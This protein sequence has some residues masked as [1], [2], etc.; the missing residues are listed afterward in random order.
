MV[1][2]TL[3]YQR[4]LDAGHFKVTKILNNGRWYPVAMITPKGKTYLAKRHKEYTQARLVEVAI[5]TQV[6]AMV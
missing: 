5:E 3:P 2:S 1:S 6:G 4:F